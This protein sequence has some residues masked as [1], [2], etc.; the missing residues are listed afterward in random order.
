MK[1]I[2][3]NTKGQLCIN[4]MI[5]QANVSSPGKEFLY[6]TYLYEIITIFIRLHVHSFFILLF[7]L[8]IYFPWY[9]DFN[10]GPCTW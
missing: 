4:W 1:P 9:L 7:Y 3:K 10:L 2:S 6:L 8:F 5:L